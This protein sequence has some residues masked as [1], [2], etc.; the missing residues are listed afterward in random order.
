MT[1]GRKVPE[2]L[3]KHWPKIEHCLKTPEGEHLLH[4]HVD[5]E[6]GQKKN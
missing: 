2:F 5:V 6:Y 4:K 3:T 1:Q